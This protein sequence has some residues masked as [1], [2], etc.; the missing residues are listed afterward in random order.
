MMLASGVL[1]GLSV[2]M[3]QPGVFFVLMGAV[4]ILREFF[5][6]DPNDRLAVADLLVFL[7]GVAAPIIA[8]LAWMMAAGVWDRFWFWTVT[9]GFAY[10]SRVGI[11]E[12][13]AIASGII[14]TIVLPAIII[15]IVAAGG[16][17]ALRRRSLAVHDR[18]VVI[19]FLVLSFLAVTTGFL[20]RRHYFILMLPAIAVFF[21][22]GVEQAGE[23]FSSREKLRKLFWPAVLVLT[24]AG[25]GQPF[26]AG[27]EV[28]FSLSP[29]QASREMFGVNPFVESERIAARVREMTG[30]EE[31]ILV[32]GSEPQIYFYAERPPATGYLY[33]YSLMEDQPYAGQMQEELIAQV[34]RSRPGI[35]LFVNVPWSWLVRP[36][37]D[38]SVI[39]WFFEYRQREGYELAGIVDI[40]SMT[41]TV[42]R[43]GPDAAGY[44]PASKS[45][46]EVW[47]LAD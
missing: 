2:L 39:D 24:I 10:G 7:A 25:L 44:T 15:W 22:L 29:N 13:I 14:P 4:V 6:E 37:S 9:Y 47:R 38:M 41:E 11:A 43:W 36:E 5:K 35:L 19:F 34:E 20:F 31:R 45:F 32:F 46:I 12:G 26:I 18:L 23:F 16:I 3:K 33:T 27:R 21:A 30:E 28:L 17:I 8:V 1:M 42:W 40:V